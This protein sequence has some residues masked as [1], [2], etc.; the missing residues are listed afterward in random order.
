MPRGLVGWRRA[1][2]VIVEGPE[3]CC[4]EYVS[5]MTRRLIQPAPAATH[6]LNHLRAPSTLPQVRSLQRL[7]WQQMVVRGEQVE[8]C[9]DGMRVDDMRRLHHGFEVG[10]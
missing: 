4:R 9:P 6:A 8:E 3:A 10:T 5:I 1:G 7:R 2:I